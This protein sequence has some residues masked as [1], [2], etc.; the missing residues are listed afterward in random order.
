ML[1][2]K[3][4]EIATLCPEDDGHS[5]FVLRGIRVTPAETVAASAHVLLK[6]SNSGGSDHFDPFILPAKAALKIAAALPTGSKMPSHDQ[7]DIEHFEGAKA[8][9]ISVTNDD[10]DCDVYTTQPIEEEF[11]NTDTV[12]PDVKAAAVEIIL[13]LDILIPLLQ[14]ISEFHGKQ[15]LDEP[16]KRR[17]AT[18]RFYE[19]PKGYEAAQRIDAE[20]DLGQELTAVVMPC[21]GAV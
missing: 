5:K 7:A 18:F 9:R 13:D 4:F 15:C 10:G 16:S 12:I 14:R 20:N 3:N 6:I 1:N 8:V 2:K 17:I 11:P 19:G 21:R